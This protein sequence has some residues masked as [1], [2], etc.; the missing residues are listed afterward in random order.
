MHVELGEP[1]VKKE[2]GLD[3]GA[4]VAL[5]IEG[6]HSDGLFGINEGHDITYSSVHISLLR[7][8]TKKRTHCH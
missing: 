6:G 3:F 2:R 8:R 1:F 5:P 7:E 4:D